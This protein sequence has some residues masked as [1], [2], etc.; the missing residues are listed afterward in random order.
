MLERAGLTEFLGYTDLR[1]DATIVGL[2]V[3]GV[4]GPRGRRGR[5]R[6]G[7]ARP[8]PVLRRGRRP[9]GRHRAAARRRR[10]TSRSPTCRPRCRACRAPRRGPHGEVTRRRRRSSAQIDVERRARDLPRAHRDAPRA[11][12]HPQRPRRLGGPGRLAQRPGPAAL[13]L[14]LAGGRRA[15]QRAAPTSR[16]RSTRCSSTTSR[17]TR[18]RHVDGRGPRDRRVALFGEKYGDEVR[19]VEVG[20]YS[21]ELCGGTHVAPLRPARPGQGAGRGVH[22]LRRPPGRG[23]RRHRRLPVPGPRARAGRPARRAAQGPPRGAA[24]ADRRLVD[25]LRAA[26]KE[27]ETVRAGA[28]L[29]SAGELADGAEDVGGIALVRRPRRPGWP[30]DDLRALAARRA[31]PRLRPGRRRRRC[32]RPTAA[33]SPFVVATTEAARER[34]LAAGDLVGRSRPRSAAGAAASRTWPRAGAATPAG[35]PTRDRGA[36]RGAGVR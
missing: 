23:A 9:A 19:I 7:R 3:D 17:S 20:D 25:R 35:S 30:A 29:A 12:R 33:R 11:R 26:E 10:S 31:R 21:R 4:A 36:A 15:G 8:H 34:G 22:R 18:V 24:R 1:A 32:S 28:V 2:L 6:R 13:R 27:L 5:R 14:H 16:T